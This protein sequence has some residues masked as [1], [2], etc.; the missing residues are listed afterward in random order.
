MFDSVRLGYQNMLCLIE[1][2]IEIII[3]VIAY[4]GGEAKEFMN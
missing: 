1:K 4:P 3:F 2:M